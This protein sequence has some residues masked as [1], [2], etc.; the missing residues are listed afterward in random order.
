MEI[1]NLSKATSMLRGE[2]VL[3]DTLTYREITSSFL[4]KGKTDHKNQCQQGLQELHKT[5]MI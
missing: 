3:V 1:R 5:A 4:E 2:L